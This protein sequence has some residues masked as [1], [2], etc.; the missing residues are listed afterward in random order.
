MVVAILVIFICACGGNAP[1]NYDAYGDVWGVN[2]GGGTDDDQ[3]TGGDETDDA[4]ETVNNT[5]EDTIIRTELGDASALLLSNGGKLLKWTG[6]GVLY[7]VFES[8]GSVHL[9]SFVIADDG[10]VYMRFSSEVFIDGERCSLARASRNSET[11]CIEW[12]LNVQSD[13]RDYTPL[14]H[15]DD[16]GN[17][18]FA[19]TD[20]A[21]GIPMVRKH[22]F[23]DSTT[24]TVY[25]D[26]VQLNNFNVSA[27]GIVYVTGYENEASFF[28]SVSEDGKVNK[29]TNR[30]A[31]LLFRKQDG[32]MFYSDSSGVIEVIGH[33]LDD[34]Y[35]ISGDD[36]TAVFDV[37]DNAYDT[38]VYPN[39]DFYSSFCSWRGGLVSGHYETEGGTVY[40]ISGS[41]A[42]RATLWRYWP[43]IRPVI[44]DILHPLKLRGYSHY[45]FT[46]GATATGSVD[47][48][49]L[50]T[51][52]GVEVILV[53]ESHMEVE[54]FG[55]DPSSSLIL[56]S[57]FDPNSSEHVF[58]TINANG[59]NVIT[60]LE[61]GTIY[62]RIQA[63]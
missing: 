10:Y 37:N 54:E 18:Y 33:E 47:L 46:L 45:L 30:S 41:G 15:F 57:G 61:R 34:H 48:S 56:F 2:D 16:D 62:K 27:D 26:N 52:V 44:L 3:N 14:I 63:F 20:Y 40:T 13:Y 60:V 42:E 35:Y 12:G 4:D 36:P 39:S 9:N 22:D 32:E 38:C 6:S 7:D 49:M 29:L 23:S 21:D 19:A 58:G 11:E 50:D 5:I 31:S 24:T 1:E 43:S 51:S 25:R 17:L 28:G 53:D 55:F 8:N 59:R